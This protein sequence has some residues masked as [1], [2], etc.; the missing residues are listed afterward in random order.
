MKKKDAIYAKF[1]H[2]KMLVYVVQSDLI[3]SLSG[4]SQFT[5]RVSNYFDIAL[6]KDFSLPFTGLIPIYDTKSLSIIV[7]NF[8]PIILFILTQ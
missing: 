7:L 1:L 8:C 3:K 5:L 2:T 4:Q 6:I